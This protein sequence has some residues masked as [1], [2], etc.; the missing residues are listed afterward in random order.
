MPRQPNGRPSIY[1]GKDGF[2]HAYVTVGTN[3]DGTP[4]RKHVKRRKA[5]DVAEA[6]DK[7]LEQRRKTGATTIGKAETLTEWLRYWL[8]NIVKDDRT[9]ATWRAYTPIVERHIIPAIGHRRLTGTRN[10]LEPDDV[11]RVY[12]QMRSKGRQPSYVLQAHR[13]LRRALKLAVRRGR[14]DRNVCDLIDAPQLRRTKIKGY[15]L[16]EAQAILRTAA[17]DPMA[18]R[19]L[20]GLLVG[21]RQGE[22]LGL[23][24]PKVFLDAV[25]PYISIEVQLQRR[26]WEHGC[27]DPAECAKPHCRT[28]KCPPKY[29]HGC[30]TPGAC[31][32][33]AH[34][35]PQRQ[36]VAG[37]SQH[38]GKTG[39][40]PLCQPGC[41]RHAKVCP[42]RHGGGLVQAPVKS[43][44]GE[45][46]V[47]LPPVVVA[48]LERLRE[49]A[50]RRAGPG[51]WDGTGFVFADERGNPIDPRRDHEAWE[52][53]LRR[54][55]VE[56]GR[57]HAARHTAASM[58]IASGTDISVVQELL[59]HA[60]IRVTRGYVDVASD[61]KQQAVDRVAE[62]L[63][64]G[65][66]RL[67]LQPSGATH[68][69]KR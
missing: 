43:Q 32:K 50:I 4:R 66:L 31:K 21:P 12:R 23:Q 3:P 47:N 49:E 22:C 5:G 53:L 9:W 68:A 48:L 44:A 29:V 16:L 39:C 30:D 60:D 8:D 64:D 25:Q 37:C 46:L 17:A 56:D 51:L 27:D 11:E 63:L 69:A 13:V 7:L 1:L 35:C 26:V 15:A 19:W 20:L 10:V 40:P 54:A 14:A 24:W 45:R 18:A 67:L 52:D 28:T 42:Q 55:G 41:T 57:L 59:G 36:V 34:F 2:Y 6:V 33:L 38:R 58:L 61:L 62:A 65:D